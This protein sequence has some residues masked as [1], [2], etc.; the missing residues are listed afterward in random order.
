M[1]KSFDEIDVVRSLD[2]VPLKFDKFIPFP[3][4]LPDS[5]EF[6]TRYKYKD[7]NNLLG[8][9]SDPDP[10]SYSRTQQMSN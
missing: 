1:L 5:Q 4:F 7:F 6:F 2:S 10:S 9:E 3:M 8:P